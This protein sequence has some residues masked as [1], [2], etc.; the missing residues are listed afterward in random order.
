M[1]GGTAGAVAGRLGRAL[2]ACAAALLLAAGIIGAGGGAARAQEAAPTPGETAPGET[3]PYVLL[4][5]DEVIYDEKAR[6]TTAIGAVE[7]AH[8]AQVLR[9]DRVTYDETRDLVTA[10][11]NVVVLQPTGEVLFADRAEFTDGLKDGVVEGFRMLL[12][13]DSRLAAAGGTRTGG[14]VTTLNRAVYSPCELCK[15]DPERAPLWRVRAVRVIHDSDKK[16]VEYQDAFLEMFGIPVFY[17]P[18]LSHP[19]PSVKRRTGFLAPSY[20]SNS[21][22]GFVLKTPFFWEIAPNE[23]VTVTPHFMSDEADVLEANYRRRFAN[24]EV[25]LDGSITQPDRRDR[26]GTHTRGHLFAKGRFD[27]DDIWRTRFQLQHSSDDTYLRRYGFPMENER[28]LTSTFT[29]EGFHGRNYAQISGYSFQGLRETDDPGQSPLVL[30]YASYTYTSR[31]FADGS[32]LTS[33]S[34][35]LLITRGE[36]TDSRR[37]SLNNGWH[38]PYTASSGEMYRLSATLQTDLYSAS[39]VATATGTDS[40]V[41]GRVFPQIMGEWRYPLVRADANATQ[42]VEPRAAVILAPNG[43]NPELIPNED[44][45]NVEFDHTNLFSMNRF[46]GIDRVENGTRFVYG[47]NWSLYGPEGGSVETF[48]G[49]SY[50][51]RRQADFGPASGLEDRLSDIVG[52]VRASPGSWI[53]L[54]YRFRYDPDTNTARRSEAQMTVGPRDFK[55]GINYLFLDE[56]GQGVEFG[57]RE[58]LLLSFWTRISQYWSATGHTRRNLA[59]GGGTLDQRLAL[60]YE[61]ECFIF[62][63]VGT[64]NFTEDRDVR[65]TDSLMFQLVFRNL[66]EFSASR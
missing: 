43:G 21:D 17:T 42:I 7:I 22:F 55:L 1:A 51:L 11:G 59:Q 6:L 30:P 38:L 41:T 58:E 15:D 16:D 32:Y 33:D 5:A 61:D 62:S 27:H 29:T 39:K 14:V 9:A 60:I 3:T 12:T 23:D 50:R 54:L 31:P 47:V 26:P 19:D 44:S 37:L 25:E 57:D 40:G 48:L 65:P 24:G 28:A 34:S 63:I 46:G 10:T 35:L 49:Q 13:D 64:R 66:G 53:D 36:G 56:S 8:G 45:S 20:G 18:Y 52:Q 2:A 4:R